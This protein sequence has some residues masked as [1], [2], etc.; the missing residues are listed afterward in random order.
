MNL[1]VPL[2]ETTSWMVYRGHDISHSLLTAR[3][4]TE[5]VLH[6]NEPQGELEVGKVSKGG[7][8]LW[9]S[10]SRQVEK[11]ALLNVRG[12]ASKWW[13]PACNQPK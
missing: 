11:K 7:C 8:F 2:K 13:E 6:L 1:G 10:P 12:V 9:S 3:P 5:V 4:S